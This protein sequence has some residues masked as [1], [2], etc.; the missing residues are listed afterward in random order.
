MQGMQ[1]TQ[2]LC[3]DFF[4]LSACYYITSIKTNY[5]GID[6]YFCDL[7]SSEP[8]SLLLTKWLMNDLIVFHMFSMWY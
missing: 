7:A 8:L 3:P 1:F 4:D 2:M 5:S 6:L